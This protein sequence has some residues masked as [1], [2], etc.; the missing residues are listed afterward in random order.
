MLSMRFRK[1]NLHGFPA[2]SYSDNDI[3]EATI[4]NVRFAIQVQSGSQYT[5]TRFVKLDN[6]SGRQVRHHATTVHS[7]CSCHRQQTFSP[8]GTHCRCGERG[9]FRPVVVRTKKAKLLRRPSFRFDS[10]ATFNESFEDLDYTP[11]RQAIVLRTV[12]LGTGSATQYWT[13]LG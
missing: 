7:I 5:R 3:D 12:K 6:T 1:L 13:G 4:N 8:S 10:G 2:H 9:G 11:L